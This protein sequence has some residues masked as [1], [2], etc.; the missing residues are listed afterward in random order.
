MRK[1]GGTFFDMLPSRCLDTLARHLGAVQFGDLPVDLVDRLYGVISERYPPLLAN[2]NVLLLFAARLGVFDSSAA[3]DAAAAAAAPSHMS[4]SDDD[5]VEGAPTCPR[6]AADC[7][8]GGALPAASALA[9]P[10]ARDEHPAVSANG[11][12]WINQHA[13]LRTYAVNM[14]HRVLSHVHGSKRAVEEA[15]SQLIA[16]ANAEEGTHAPPQTDGTDRVVV[17]RSARGWQA[18]AVHPASSTCC[19]L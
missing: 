17:V 6:T 19:V 10:R 14:E 8:E 13:P 11:F 3:A 9:A 18:Q 16:A 5:G 1:E 15:N 7:P 4:Q 2:K 12:R